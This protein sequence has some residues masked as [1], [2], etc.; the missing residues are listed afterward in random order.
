M[1][2]LEKK[3]WLM[4]NK[5]DFRWRGTATVSIIVVFLPKT[6][7]IFRSWYVSALTSMMT[8]HRIISR[9][10]NFI[11]LADGH[12]GCYNGETEHVTDP[13]GHRSS[14][15]LETGYYPYSTR[16]NWLFVAPVGYV[17]MCERA[18]VRACVRACDRPTDR[19]DPT[20]PDPTRPDPTRPGPARPGPAR[21]DP[22][23][24]DPTRPDPARPGP[25]RPD[26]IRFTLVCLFY[27]YACNST[28]DKGIYNGLRLIE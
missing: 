23:R 18:C 16:C 15:Y 26:P 12:P 5:I 10:N 17:S 2:H 25:T 1:G 6:S 21:P 22:T 13:S 14:P 7:F 28:G 11:R 24:P 8:S 27:A 4:L 9:I 20:R 19:P 3:R